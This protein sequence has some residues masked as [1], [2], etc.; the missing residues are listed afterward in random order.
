MGFARSFYENRIALAMAA[1]L[2][3]SGFENG[4]GL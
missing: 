3:A 4:L 2:E 1:G